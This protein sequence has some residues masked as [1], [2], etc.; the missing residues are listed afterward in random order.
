HP[1]QK[2]NCYCA[3]CLAQRKRMLKEVRLQENRLYHKKQ[4]RP[5]PE[6]NQLSFINKLFLLSILDEQVQ[7]YSQHREYIDWH[8]IRYFSI[9]PNYLFQHG[10]IKNML[11]RKST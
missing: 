9:S 4:D 1:D 5:V 3:Q 10:L 6:L 7:E 8:H 11:D 2:N